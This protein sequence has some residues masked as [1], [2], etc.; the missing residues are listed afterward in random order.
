MRYEYDYD[1]K[2]SAHLCFDASQIRCLVA[3]SP[4]SMPWWSFGAWGLRVV[5]DLHTALLQFSVSFL[6]CL[7]PRWRRAR[8]SRGNNLLAK[9]VL[10]WLASE[11]ELSA[12][13]ERWLLLLL[14]CWSKG[15]REGGGSRK[16]SRSTGSSSNRR[17]GRGSWWWQNHT[18]FPGH[19]VVH[20][21]VWRGLVLCPATCKTERVSNRFP[22]RCVDVTLTH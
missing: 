14:W 11:S 17:R 4:S 1:Y 7:I 6:C 13:S 18:S 3:L 8:L 9:P 16:W 22:H 2:N 19:G 12:E 10:P 15:Q 20:A 21:I 5:I